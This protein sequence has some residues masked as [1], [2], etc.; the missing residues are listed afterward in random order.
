[1]TTGKIDQLSDSGLPTFL[2]GH[3]QFGRM[4]RKSVQAAAEW[5]FLKNGRPIETG[6][7]QKLPT[8]FD[9]VPPQHHNAIAFGS[10]VAVSGYIQEAL[11][12]YD[13]IVLNK[14]TLLLDTDINFLRDGQRI[15][16]QGRGATKAKVVGAGAGRVAFNCHTKSD[17]VIED[18]LFNRTEGGI[19]DG[20]TLFRFE[21]SHTIGMQGVR[22]IGQVDTVL[23]LR[24]GPNQYLY[25]FRDNYFEAICRKNITMGEG[26]AG[27]V[28]DTWMDGMF[29]KG[30]SVAGVLLNDASGLF[31]GT[32]S[33]LGGQ[34]ALLVKPDA[35]DIARYVLGGMLICDST[36]GPTVVF[37]AS[38]GGVIETISTG[39]WG[40]TSLTDHG[41]Y[42]KEGSGTINAVRLDI[43][44][45]NSYKSGVYLDGGSRYDLDLQVGRNG[46]QGSG[47]HSNVHLKNVQDAYLTGY[48]AE[49]GSSDF[50]ELAAH[51]IYIE[52]DCRDVHIS[53]VGCRGTVG[54][55]IM[56]LV[57]PNIDG[58]T[59]IEN[60]VGVTTEVVVQVTIAV[61]Q[62]SGSAPH[63]LSLLP[64]LKDVISIQPLNP[65]PTSG[66]YSPPIKAGIDATV[67]A[68]VCD[69]AVAGT[70]MVCDV[71]IKIRTGV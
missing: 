11:E 68:L 32:L 27:P 46:I 64:T 15:Y 44:A 31:F 51:A 69:P 39:I 10:G 48:A 4:R 1:M 50:P 7:Q 37:D 43:T 21:N 42:A 62:T 28:Q 52:G 18:I 40:A 12:A 53:D 29:L 70:P 9:V 56:D 5:L 58:S 24:G 3:D 65:P 67:V 54:A 41:I 61:G 14:G 26:G 55:P 17:C 19:N 47:L 38:L 30:G 22:V 13:S 49:L 20:L 63:G 6:L 23:D 36:N 57:D 34:T 45:T 60:C 25:G 71:R 66:L 33:I 8:L 2:V 35:D 16:G 59:V